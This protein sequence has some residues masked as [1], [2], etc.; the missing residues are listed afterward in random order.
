MNSKMIEDA[1]LEIQL[2]S[3]GQIEEATAHKWAARAVAAYRNYDTS[4]D[5]QWRLDAAKYFDEAC[6]HASL[7][8]D[9]GVTLRA[10]REWMR[11]YI[12]PSGFR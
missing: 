10:V 8:D 1:Q 9:S 4:G 5:I 2:N 12:P 7:A 6:E 3:S 11:R